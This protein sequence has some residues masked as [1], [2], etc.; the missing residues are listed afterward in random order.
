MNK[1]QRL[2]TQTLERSW[3]TIARENGF[4]E[5]ENINYVTGFISP[6]GVVIQIPEREHQTYVREFEETIKLKERAYFKQYGAIR[7]RPGRVF[8]FLDIP[9]DSLNVEIWKKPTLKQVETLSKITSKVF[10]DFWGDKLCNCPKDGVSA[11]QFM[12]DLKTYW[13]IKR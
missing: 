13:E 2:R 5:N 11:N 3:L 8:M 9:W 10:Y 12:L 4:V 1:Y 7:I 6:S